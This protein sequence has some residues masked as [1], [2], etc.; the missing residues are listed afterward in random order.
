MSGAVHGSL[1]LHLL[2]AL[3]YQVPYLD[4]RPLCVESQQ[5]LP[6]LLFADTPEMLYPIELWRIWDIENGGDMH[7]LHDLPHP[8]VHAEVVEE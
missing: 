4:C 6:V 2:D 7:L 5:L 1:L 8:L 3:F